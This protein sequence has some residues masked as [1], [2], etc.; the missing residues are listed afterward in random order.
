MQNKCCDFIRMIFLIVPVY[1]GCS[2]SDIAS[3][4]EKLSKYPY[5]QELR[6]KNFNVSTLVVTPKQKSYRRLIDSELL[7]EAI[8]DSFNFYM[9]SSNDIKT[10]E[11][12]IYITPKGN[13]NI[14]TYGSK[15]IIPSGSDET[16]VKRL[17]FSF[18]Q[19]VKIKIGDELVSPDLSHMEKTFLMDDGATFWVSRSL[20]NLEVEQLK[21][22]N[23]I[24][25]IIEGPDSEELPFKFKWKM[26]DL[27]KGY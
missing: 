15:N 8:T 25:L 21:K 5:R 18:G 10:L 23:F 19:M 2:S 1:M 6:G 22:E 11:F 12:A 16:Y 3:E 24:E 26:K 4:I 27:I 17:M 9:K 7:A 14:S 13:I 20:D